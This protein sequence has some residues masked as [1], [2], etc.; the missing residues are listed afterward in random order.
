MILIYSLEN[1]GKEK[2]EV[3]CH[4]QTIETPSIWPWLY[5]SLDEDLEKKLSIK[6]QLESLRDTFKLKGETYRS[7][8]IF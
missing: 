5:V 3:C 7:E 2:E 6:Y 4:F 8:E 1:R